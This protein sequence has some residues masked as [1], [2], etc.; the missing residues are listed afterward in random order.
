MVAAVW[1]DE[2]RGGSRRKLSRQIPAALPVTDPEKTGLSL[3]RRARARTSPMVNSPRAKIPAAPAQRHAA[4]RWLLFGGAAK[5]GR[6][7]LMLGGGL[8]AAV[9]IASIVLFTEFDWSAVTRA[10]GRLNPFAVLP[11]MA[12]LPVFG[13]PIVVVYLVAGARF[14]PIGGGVV[15][16]AVT[17]VHLVVTHAIARSVLR[18]PAARLLARR[19]RHLPEVPADEHAAVALIAALVPG[20]PYVARNYLL[21]LSGVRLRIYFWICLPIYVAR[22]YVTI[23]LGDMSGDPSA[24]RLAILFGVDALKV[25]LCAYVIWRL[26]EHHRRVHGA[27]ESIATAPPSGAAT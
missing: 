22:S 27:D 13:F 2:G 3:A 23:L 10:I 4:H 20:L 11:L 19:H 24:Q 25:A 1:T 18:G 21:A 15:V 6:L 8:L 26:R 12:L 17:A 14:G 5:R 16:T 7:W 9:A